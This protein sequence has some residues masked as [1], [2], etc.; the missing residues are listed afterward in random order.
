M[1]PAASRGVGAL[2]GYVA[3]RTMDAATSVFYGR[4]TDAS[5]VREEELAPGGTLVQLGKQLGA[6][7][8]RELDDAQAGRL[9]LVVHRTFGTLYGVA[10]ATLV[11]RGVAPLKAGLL[12]AT[13]AW[14]LVDEGTAL[15]TFTDYPVESHLRGVVG[16]GTFGLA[17][18]LILT[19][20]DRD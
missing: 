16:H 8:G 7:T 1:S 17:A 2:A 11:R 9:G 20:L 3:S 13:A 14:V 15:P 5:K 19:L 6:A 18:G 4:Q 12:V 10:A